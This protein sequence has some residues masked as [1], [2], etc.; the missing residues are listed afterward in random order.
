MVI[1]SLILFSISLIFLYSCSPQKKL[2]RLIKKHPELLEISYDTIRVRDTIYIETSRND[3]TTLIQKHDST[4]V[5]NNEKIYLKYFYDTLTRE[6]YH[7]VECKGDT[8][9]YYKEIPYKVE[10][11]VFK[12]LSWWDKYKT[13]LYIILGVLVALFLLKRFK[14]YLPI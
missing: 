10:K 4:I 6:I 14:D 12:E 7:E 5:I 13:I 8:V 3:T 1:R 11:V 2:N 9:Y